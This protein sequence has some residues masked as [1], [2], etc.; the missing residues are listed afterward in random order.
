MES[1]IDE[2]YRLL[3]IEHYL[4]NNKELS[5]SGGIGKLTFSCPFCGPLGRSEA[6]SSAAF[7]C[8]FFA[9]ERPNGPQN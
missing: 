3:L 7:R 8:F 2:R 4:E 6:K 1:V 9:S 5:V